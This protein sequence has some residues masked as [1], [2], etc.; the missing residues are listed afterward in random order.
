MVTAGVVTVVED[1]ASVIVV[2]E[3]EDLKE[4]SW[5]PGKR[6]GVGGT[7]EGPREF[8]MFSF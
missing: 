7:G 8:S 6:L 1:V 2:A 5:L 3:V 4:V